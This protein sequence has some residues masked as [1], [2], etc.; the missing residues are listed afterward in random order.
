[1]NDSQSEQSEDDQYSVAQ[2]PRSIN[3]A[4][5]TSSPQ[6]STYE[7]HH[8]P[9]SALAAQMGHGNIQT[10]PSRETTLTPL[11]AAQQH[12]EQQ[13]QQQQQ[14]RLD[15]QGEQH[16]K[17]AAVPHNEYPQD[18]MTM[19]CRTGPPSERSSAPS[20]ARP[21]SRDSQSDYSNPTSFSSIEPTSGK[22][23]PVKGSSN[24]EQL[25]HKKKSGFFQ[26]HSPFRRKSK[27]DLNRN[28]EA[29]SNVTTPSSRNTW[30][31]RLTG[32]SSN[33]SPT[34]RPPAYGQDAQAMVLGDPRHM[35]G[36]PEP[37]DPRANFQ[38]NVGNNVFDVASPDKRQNNRSNTAP[39]PDTDDPI[40]AALAE[41]KGVTK[42]SSIR[43]SADRYHGLSTPAPDAKLQSQ[44]FANPVSSAQRG[45]PPPSYDTPMKRLD[46]P[47]P[48]FT[49]AQMQQTR[50][51]YIDQTAAVFGSPQAPRSTQGS[52]RPSTRGNSSINGAP[53]RA[54]SPA[55]PR[56]ASPRPGYGS[57]RQQ[58]SSAQGRYQQ[59][60]YG[61][62]QHSPADRQDNHS[63]AR[64]ASP[65]PMYA[66]RGA[67]GSEMTLAMPPQQQQ[68]DGESMYRGSGGRG[69][70]GA[71]R[72]TSYYDG[73]GGSY[74][75]QHG[76][77]QGGRQRSKSTAAMGS[78]D[79]RQQMTRDGRQI[80]H[81]GK[82]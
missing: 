82:L 3:P 24:D 8:D 64:S 41:L 39:T 13:R 21:S 81:Y 71:G 26:G 18:G 19:Y 6:P 15:Y 80:I 44:Q 47:Q 50:Q 59:G 23:S 38:L 14:Q 28:D 35:S 54:T 36:S 11:H 34:R 25:A 20:P 60:G 12:Q 74:G 61:S 43:Q 1:M 68:Q 67:V 72:P 32:G 33:T 79:G 16:G 55:P 57:G 22:Q 77:Q 69:R 27:R 76:Q 78:S 45:T 75:S 10:P 2:F 48:A 49:S 4:Y 7:S 52:S 17:L 29:S 9:N 58:P 5:R 56:S 53:L 31:A 65:S 30:S 46:L 51:K 63:I 66:Q 70:H 40:A 73:G 37:A 62:R 42:A